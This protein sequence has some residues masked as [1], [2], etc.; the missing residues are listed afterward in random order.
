MASLAPQEN[1]EEET[2]A[3]FPIN[4]IDVMIFLLTFNFTN[5]FFLQ[6]ILFLFI[7]YYFSVNFEP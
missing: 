2:T 5:F 1:L 4:K 6:R 3:F 7:G